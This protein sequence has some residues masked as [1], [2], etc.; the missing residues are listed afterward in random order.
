MKKSILALLIL[1]V[2]LPM[3]AQN[4]VETFDDNRW[5]FQEGANKFGSVSVE[6]GY[7]VLNCKKF[8]MKSALGLM[9]HKSDAGKQQNLWNNLTKSFARVPMRP[10]DN[11]KL[12]IKYLVSNPMAMMYSIFFNMDKRILDEEESYSA[13]GF[14]LQMGAN[15]YNLIIG[16]GMQ[17]AD[18]LPIKMKGKDFPMTF[19]IEKKGRNAI[20]ELNGIEIY[21]GECAL[22]EPCIG[23]VCQ[24]AKTYLKIDEIILEQ[25]EEE[26]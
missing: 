3:F 26:D 8:D 9:S 17:H 16:D 21:R 25:A 6:D 23:F 12:T 19:T 1:A 14:L 11:Y 7:L 18:K 4:K 10:T 22:T 5:G 2:S 13:S 20:F 24:M 15:Q